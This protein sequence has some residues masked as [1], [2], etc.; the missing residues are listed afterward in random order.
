MSFKTSFDM[1][2]GI[3][4]DDHSQVMLRPEVFVFPQVLLS[5]EIDQA[6]YD[7][8]REQLG[9]AGDDELLVIQLTT[10]GGDPEVARMMGEDIRFRRQ[11]APSCRHLF[12]GKTAVYSAGVTFMSAF[13][14]ED[15]FLS[16]HCRLLIHERILEKA[17]E[18]SGPISACVATA[19][20]VLNEIEN[21]IAIQEEGFRDLV[22][23]SR[24][25]FDEVRDRAPENWYLDAAQ[26]R[27]LG[28]VVQVV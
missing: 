13:P 28:L 15:R 4:M 20:A 21:A 26:A 6:M 27:S 23:G 9:K 7:S 25:S 10:L 16:V 14:V 11:A 19:K 8:F 24:V 2:G 18:L 3:F 5:G 12:V 22:R 17:L 1:E